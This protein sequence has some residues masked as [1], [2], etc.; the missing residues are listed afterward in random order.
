MFDSLL[1]DLMLVVLIGILSQ[2]V[3]WRFRM[4][5][6]VVMSVAG[7]LVGPIFGL[8]NPQESMG[9]LF[10]PIITF[11]VALILFEGSLNLDFKEIR[12][13]NKPVLRIITIGAFIAWIAGSLAAHYVA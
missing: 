11:A 13:F 1:F 3:A 10:G 2:W 4:P 5:A 9:D 6:I 8:I 7:L 12:G